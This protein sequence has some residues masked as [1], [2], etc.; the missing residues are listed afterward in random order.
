MDEW[1][2]IIHPETGGIGEVHRSSLAQHYAAG[3]RLLAEDDIPEPEPEPEPEPMTRAQAAKAARAA[4]Q[5]SQAETE[6]M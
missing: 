5:A 2:Q 4:E 6:G 1:V 3:W